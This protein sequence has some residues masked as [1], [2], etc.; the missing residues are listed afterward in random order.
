MGRYE[1]KCLIV[2]L[3]FYRYVD[4]TS[5]LLK[6]VEILHI[7]VI[8]LLFGD[9]VFVLF[10]QRYHTVKSFYLAYTLLFATRFYEFLHFHFDR[11]A[12]IVGIFLNKSFY[13][14]FVKEFR[15]IFFFGIVAQIHYYAS[16]VTVFLRFLNLITVTTITRPYVSIFTAVCFTKY[17]HL[18]TYHESGIKTNA[19]LSNYVDFFVVFVVFLEFLRATARDY[20]QVFV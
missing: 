1:K 11:I 10:P 7:E 19:K 16:T 6:I 12:D 2:H 18:F 17:F 5:R 3:T 9:L 20:A 14:V 13:M 8:I 4:N 15:I